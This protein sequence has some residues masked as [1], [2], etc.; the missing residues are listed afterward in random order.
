[1]TESYIITISDGQTGT[2]LATARA[3]IDASGARMTEIRSEAMDI[4]V[5]DAL[6]RIDF[7]LLVRTANMLAGL[8]QRPEDRDRSGE[9]NSAPRERESTSTI[10]EAVEAT[11]GQRDGR[12]ASALPP[13]T[14]KPGI[15]DDFGV[16]Y[17]RLG[18]ISKVARHYDVPH[19]IAQD[20]IRSL[21][22]QGKLANPWPR[23]KERAAR[24]K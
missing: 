17:W 23:K 5:P 13:R 16:T 2:T 9:S 10:V 6:E 24:T 15:P 4:L 11:A 8:S 20:W 21:Q 1:M 18:S 19:H 12:Q 14:Q 3:E 22:Q 7:P